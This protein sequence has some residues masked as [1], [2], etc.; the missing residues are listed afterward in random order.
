MAKEISKTH[1]HIFASRRALKA[2][3]IL[4]FVTHDIAWASY[5][6]YWP[7]ADEKDNCVQSPQHEKGAIIS[8]REEEGGGSFDR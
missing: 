7:E 3:R 2:A 4:H 6:E 1:D 5:G 8:C